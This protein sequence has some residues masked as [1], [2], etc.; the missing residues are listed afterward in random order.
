METW[1]QLPLNERNLYFLQAP[2]FWD[3]QIQN[4]VIERM[5]PWRLIF[6]RSTFPYGQGLVRH[7]WRF[8]PDKAEQR[9]L[10]RWQEIQVSRKPAGNDQGL[11]ACEDNPTLLNYDWEKVSYRGLKA[12]CMTPYICIDDLMYSWEFEQQI[13][14]IYNF[15]G[16]YHMEKDDNFS[17]ET[18]LRFA[19]DATRIYVLSRGQYTAVT[20]TYNPRTVDADS[21]NVLTLSTNEIMPLSMR[22][23][24]PLNR[25]FEHQCPGGQIS[26]PVNGRRI[27]GGMLDLED[28]ERM[29]EQDAQLRDDYRNFKAE[30]NI[31]GFGSVMTF[32]G[33]ALIH[34]PLIPRWDVKTNDGTTLTLKRVNPYVLS[35]TGTLTSNSG[36]AAGQGR[37]IANPDY[38]NAQFG[39]FFPMV[40]DVLE[41]QIPN[42]RPASPGGGTSFDPGAGFEGSFAW[43]NNKDN[44]YNREGNKGYY[45][46]K[47]HRFPYPRRYDREATAIIYRRFNEPNVTN[48]ELLGTVNAI[49]SPTAQFAVIGNAA[50]V[51]GSTTLMT[52]TLPGVANFG[53]ASNKAISISV[54]GAAGITAYVVNSAGRPIYTVACATAAN[55]T[56]I[57]AGTNLVVSWT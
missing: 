38:Q 51:S 3:S 42:A 22:H 57:L 45:F 15:L 19:N 21:D 9:G 25:Y 50:A 35:T 31:E 4:R 17:C 46:Y 43:I 29:I 8:H 56:T 32:R 36:G 39:T 55:R 1:A 30:V 27:Y 34:N 54:D 12:T 16:D 7:A 53:N 5:S 23:L 18:M 48:A 41:L 33:W 28:F 2:E 10:Q 49:S 44:Q 13:M 20:G 6:E 24:S 37:W 14:A 52:L 40:K 47:S 26:A 11:D